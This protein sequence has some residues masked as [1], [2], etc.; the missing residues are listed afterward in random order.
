[1]KYMANGKQKIW[2]SDLIGEDYKRWHNEFV[3][4]DC[5]TACGKTYFC[6]RK[7]G[8]YASIKKRRILYLCNRSKLKNQTYG[9]VKDQ[10]LQAT[11]YVTTYQAFQKKIQQ[12][13]K[14]P[15]YDYIIADECHYFTTDAGFNNY[16]DVAYNYVMKQKESVVVFVSATAKSFFKYLRDTNKVKKKNSYRLDKDYSYVSKLF[17]YQSEELP[18][19]IDDILDDETDSK[20]IVFCN[21]GDRILD[22]SKI[23]GDK[24]DYYCS[25]NSKQKRLRDLCGWKE[26]SSG[27]II[28]EPACIKKYAD[29][30]ITFDK[31][32]LFTTS[33][34]DNGVDLKDRKIKHI[35]TEIVDVDTM[36]QSL[37]R[38]RSLEKDDT[39]YFYIR[40]YQ[41]KGL[42]GFINRI[43]Y[44]LEPV[45][46]YKSDYAAFYK[47]YGD[48]KQREKLNK[49]KIFYNLFKKK[50]IY[51][52]IKVNECRFRKYSQDHDMYISMR[53]L[54]HKRYLED[55]LEESLT[56]N[57]EEM[58]CNVE[59]MD[60]FIL[61]LKSIE[62]KR[63]YVEDQQYIKEEFETIGLK[64]RYKG[65]N[66]F[67]GA[68]E[69]NYKNLYKSRFYSTDITGKSYVD[70][71]RV[72]DNGLLNPN[73]DKRYW[74][75]EDRSAIGNS[76]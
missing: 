32:I 18:G 55:I 69:D 37:G 41:K 5:G 49:N 1:M 17:Y 30:L 58:V 26:D 59:E 25:Q 68:L 3:I 72:L 44:H 20:I 34:L 38:K 66:T 71:R 13:D 50:N 43:N 46:L 39:C 14:I 67:N 40:L 36:I 52:Q 8:K 45:Q 16:T 27:K 4:L 10:K 63:L 64:L 33:V 61:F 31:R 22:M 12:G 74:I 60:K 19:I 70:K 76:S 29:D 35:F 42:Q 75:L 2:V 28:E 73:R 56:S 57:A 62:G 6:I 48:G 21:S 11:I 24:A 54:G 7:L 23:Y 15:H 65:I 53:D 9:Q 51:G 47:K